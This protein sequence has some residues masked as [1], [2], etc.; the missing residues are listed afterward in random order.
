[1]VCQI[2]SIMATEGHYHIYPIKYLYEPLL[3]Y[4][5]LL[6]N[7]TFLISALSILIDFSYK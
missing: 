3:P 4:D 1:M 6:D 2:V 7:I 5:S